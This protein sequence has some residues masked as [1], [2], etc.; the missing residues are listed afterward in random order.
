MTAAEIFELICPQAE[1]WQIMRELS[2]LELSDDILWRPFDTLSNGERTKALLAGMFLR[3]NSFLLIDEPT[4]HLD[5]RARQTVSDYLRTKKGF[6]LISHDRAF[7]D[8]CID[9]I[10][11]INR[12]DIEI[13]RGN[14]STWLTNRERQDA[15]ELAG[16]ARRAADGGRSVE[17]DG[18]QALERRSAL[19]E[20]VPADHRVF[21]GWSLCCS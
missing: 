21:R 6:I 19:K 7:L 13:Q 12:A 17:G 9:H 14:F 10:L 4:N 1:Q 5:M 15:F 20:V 2:L 18:G 3:E 16:C 8:G 11:S